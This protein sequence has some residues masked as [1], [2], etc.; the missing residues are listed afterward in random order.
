MN[1]FHVTGF[2]IPS[3]L[4]GYLSS[5]QCQLEEPQADANTPPSPL[6]GIV[7]S[8][9]PCR[10][11]SCRDNQSSEVEQSQLQPRAQSRGAAHVVSPGLHYAGLTAGSLINGWSQRGQTQELRGS[12]TQ[13]HPAHTTTIECYNNYIL[14]FQCTHM[15]RDHSAVSWATNRSEAAWRL[16]DRSVRASVCVSEHVGSVT[17]SHRVLQPVCS[18]GRCHGNSQTAADF[19]PMSSEDSQNRSLSTLEHTATL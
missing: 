5:W 9:C 13:Q 15:G 2:L 10:A 17:C 6:P 3:G 1:S 14:Q 19:A 4:Q 7:P 8:A 12:C 16:T 11:L 18:P